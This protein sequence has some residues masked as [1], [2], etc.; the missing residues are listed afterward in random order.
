M[1]LFYTIS[2]FGPS[3]G[4]VSRLS[5]CIFVCKFVMSLWATDIAI[6]RVKH[7][8]FRHCLSRFFT[9]DDDLQCAIAHCTVHCAVED[10]NL[11]SKS[12]R[13]RTVLCARY[14]AFA[15]AR[16]AT[17]RIMELRLHFTGTGV[18]QSNVSSS[19]GIVNSEYKK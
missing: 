8:L 17:Y 3:A 9:S 6:R 11:D 10:F 4:R 12:E 2:S 7:H 19:E 16:S 13:Y 15:G 14:H 1:T 18:L 5:V